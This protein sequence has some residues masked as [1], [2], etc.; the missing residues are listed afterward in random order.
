MYGSDHDAS[1]L[2]LR[3]LCRRAEGKDSEKCT[4]LVNLNAVWDKTGLDLGVNHV[5]TSI[6]VRK[7]QGDGRGPTCSRKKINAQGRSNQNFKLVQ[8]HHG[9]IFVR[10]IPHFQKFALAFKF[11]V[12]Q[13]KKKV[14]PSSV[15]HK[16]LYISSPFLTEN[17]HLPTLESPV[18]C[19]IAQGL[20]GARGEKD[21]SHSRPY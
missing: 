8:N 20:A 14:Q 6:M 4:T 15:K 18:I 13:K 17:R 1:G 5:A 19:I 12:V 16:F 3:N 21:Y 9:V 10:I 7:H 2:L 11:E